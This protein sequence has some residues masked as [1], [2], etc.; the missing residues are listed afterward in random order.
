MAGILA[1]AQ[2]Y[3]NSL[4]PNSASVST[5][6]NQSAN[7]IGS[8]LTHPPG[9][10]P[11]APEHCQTKGY[12]VV[13]SGT[14]EN[15]NPIGYYPPGSNPT[16]GKPG[17]IYAYLPEQFD[18]RTYGHW[19]SLVPS[20]D[21]SSFLGATIGH[22]VVTNEIGTAGIISKATTGYTTQIPALSQLLWQSTDPLSFVLNL[23][24]N[25]TVDAKA[26]VTGKVASLLSLVLP[27]IDELGT[28]RAPGPTL[29]SGNH[30]GS[31]Y[32]ISMNIGNIWTFNNIV[33][34]EVSATFD[35]L[36]TVKGDYISATVHV[37]V[38][39]DRIYSKQDLNKAMNGSNTAT[40]TSASGPNVITQL[41]GEISKISNQVG[42]TFGSA[43]N[44]TESFL[45]KTSF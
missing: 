28:F 31:K 9:S 23:Q 14:D 24:L 21:L 6:A 45:S 7:S 17:Y 37:V 32:N 40:S 8:T 41:R 12:V 16:K 3:V 30:G 36:P 44:S 5:F 27:S 38:S 33:I 10:I 22:N 35:V 15:G 2:S 26:E 34:Q 39:T 42:N 25:A 13:F 18:I 29:L 4:I 1:P 43:I 20:G 11:L 19:A